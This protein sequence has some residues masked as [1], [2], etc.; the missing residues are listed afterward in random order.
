MFSGHLHDKRPLSHTTPMGTVRTLPII[1]VRAGLGL[2]FI[3]LNNN[4]MATFFLLS[5]IIEELFS[6]VEKFLAA[7]INTGMLPGHLNGVAG[8]GL[9]AISAKNTS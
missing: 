4:D 9:N 7:A 8:T 1:I 5:L 3:Y 6:V 2:P